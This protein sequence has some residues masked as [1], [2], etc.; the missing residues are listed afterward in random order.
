MTI[1][2]FISE[3]CLK[4]AKKNYA[5]TKTD[6]YHVDVISSLDILD[7]KGYGPEKV[8]GYRCVL[9]FIDKLSRFGFTVLLKKAQTRKDF[10]KIF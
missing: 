8:R 2:F 5:T 6:V 9:I 4:P 10:L 3:I 1:K 7:L